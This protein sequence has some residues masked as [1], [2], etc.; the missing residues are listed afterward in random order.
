[1]DPP[2]LKQRLTCI[3]CTDA[4]GYSRLVDED[5]TGALRILAAHRAV[6]D[7][8]IAYHDGRIANTAGDSVLAEFGSVVAGVRA[9]V[10]IQD[11]LKT[12]NES[13]PEAQRMLFRI[14]INLGDVVVKG[15][16]LLGDGVNVAARL[17]SIAAPGG[18]LVSSSVYDQITGKLDLGFEDMGEQALKNISRPIRAFSVSGAGRA[19][20]TAARGGEATTG[21]KR[22]LAVAL[23]AVALL[24]IAAGV[25]WQQGWIGTPRSADV[26][27]AAFDHAKAKL[28]A[29]LAVSEKARMQAELRATTS[30]ADAIRAR[31][32][33]DAAALRAKAETEA[34]NTMAK[35]QSEAAALRGKATQEATRS[36]ASAADAIRARVEAD[37]AALTSKAA[38]DTG[39]AKAEADLLAMQARASQD[40]KAAQEAA[41]AKAA[42]EASVAKAAQDAAAAKVAEA[43]ATEA[44]RHDGTWFIKQQCSANRHS[45]GFNRIADFVVRGGEF[46]IERGVPGQPGYNVMRGRPAADGTLLLTGNGIGSQ[47]R[48]TGQ[49]FEIRLVGRLNVDRYVLSGGWGERSCQAEVTR[50]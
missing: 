41:V 20:R 33:A 45:S 18:I 34:A 14:G 46:T 15:N 1:M 13:L 35:A 10:E 42:Q 32:E 2:G 36:K 5:E 37:A 39:A 11:A 25:S 49:P 43:A 44:S 24:S 50:R 19:S 8:I 31:V 17:Q 26:R 23:S 12:R 21:R 48:G 27:I 6:I 30:D 7:G 38:S 16:D 22:A 4:V 28:E 29:D 9:A 47:G 3:L 40:A